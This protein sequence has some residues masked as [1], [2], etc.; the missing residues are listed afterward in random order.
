MNASI[1]PEFSQIM[2]TAGESITNGITPIFTYFVIYLAFLEKYNKGDMVTLFG[3]VRYMV[4]YSLY[5]AV[6]WCTI[7]VGWYMI[8]VP[9]GIGSFPG[10]T[11]GA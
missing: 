5:I 7:I 9:I 11:Y 2:Y 3:S 8:G 10:V 1:S 6:I 4:P